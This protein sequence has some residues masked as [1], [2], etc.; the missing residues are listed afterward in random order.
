MK[1]H[2]ITTYTFDE[3]SD[4]AKENALEWVR[5]NWHDLYSWHD[6]NAAS[7]KKFAEW[8]GAE[9]RDVDFNVS[10][11]GHTYAKISLY[12]KYTVM[13]IDDE[14]QQIVLSELRD[15]DLYNYL[16]TSEEKINESCP[17]TGYCMDEDLLDPLR[18]YLENPDPE[19]TLQD[20]VD[21]GANN[22]LKS[23]IQDWEYTYSDEGLTDF[24]SAN[25]HEFLED[26]TKY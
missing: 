18:E 13:I 2:T 9:E 24:L 12:D 8:I 15:E 16:I 26:G 7:L 4:Q 1:T 5:S 17:F 25:E 11:W 3:L 6:D 23:Y 19:V 10:M 21:E 14:Y 22:W 20:L